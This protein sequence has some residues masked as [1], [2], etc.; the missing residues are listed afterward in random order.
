MT[1]SFVTVFD[2]FMSQI[3]DYRLLSLYNEDILNDTTNLN[4]YL[5]GFMILAI[6][7]FTSCTQDLTDRDD[8]TMLFNFTMTDENKKI[9]S[10]LMVK[11]WLAKELKDILQM[12]WNI[13]DSD[14]KHYSEAQNTKSKQDVLS[15]LREECSQLLIDYGLRN[16]DWSAWVLG[17][18]M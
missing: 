4:T 10:K 17:N 9:L 6:P 13:T 15:E 14:F 11:E 5:L 16:N 1:T 12:R 18:F 3:E 7:E 2:L 8:T